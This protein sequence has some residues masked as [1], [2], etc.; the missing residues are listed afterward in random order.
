[1]RVGRLH[2]ITERLDVARAALQA[3]APVVQVRV[4]D[5]ADREVYELVC[6]VREVAAGTGATVLV[7][8][9]VHVAVAAGADGAHVGAEDLPVEAARRVLGPGR[10]LGGTARDPV[11]ARAHEAAGADYLGVGPTFRTRSKRGLPD[12]LGPA[13]VG[14]VARAVRIPVV[15]IAGITVDAVPALLDEGVHGV[16]VISAINDAD[17]P[18]A[19]TEAFLRVIEKATR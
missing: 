4:K 16:A 13:R 2:V 7:N 12:P 19:A 11:T 8:D 10:L 5:R 18:A 14:D 15:A 1:V 17:D 9:R 3:G 6:R